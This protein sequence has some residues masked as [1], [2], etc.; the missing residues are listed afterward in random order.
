MGIKDV[1]FGLWLANTHGYDESAVAGA[2]TVLGIA[3][4]SGEV[5]LTLLLLKKG[6]I[7]AGNMSVPT[8]LC[9]AASMAFFWAQA[10][11]KPNSPT[12]GLVAVYFL[13]MF[14][15]MKAV[16]CLSVAA[17][18]DEKGVEGGFPEIACYTNGRSH[19]HAAR[20]CPLAKGGEAAVRPF[21]SLQCC[22]AEMRYFGATKQPQRNKTLRPQ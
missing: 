22:V 19:W 16:Q 2:A 17:T 4:I 8:W 7:S 18:T 10:A 3:D 14:M 1:C 20:T 11:S 12:V 13:S 6:C 15:E 5:L 21:G 9:T